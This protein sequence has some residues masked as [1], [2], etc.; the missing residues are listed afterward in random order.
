MSKGLVE[1]VWEKQQEL[2]RPVTAE[3]LTPY[4]HCPAMSVRNRIERAR[5]FHVG[6]P[7]PIN[8]ALDLT[9][10]KWRGNYV[11]WATRKTLH[12]HFVE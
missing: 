12:R 1:Y 6:C 3:E 7:L 11:F 8:V 5:R 2:G 10:G 9:G 4:L